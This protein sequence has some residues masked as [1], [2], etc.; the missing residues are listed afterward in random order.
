MEAFELLRSR[1]EIAAGREKILEWYVPFDRPALIG[2]LS[3]LSLAPGVKEGF[4]HL[5]EVGVKI[6]L[7]PIT[8][9]FAVIWLASELSADYA[10]GTGWQD[11]RDIFWLEDKASYLNSLFAELNI[12]R[13]A[14]AAVGDSQ[15]DVPMLNPEAIS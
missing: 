15:G 14:L 9:E 2:Y 8:W 3:E 12:N 13:N 11:N 1:D 10:I 6:A 4:A 7:V 5:K